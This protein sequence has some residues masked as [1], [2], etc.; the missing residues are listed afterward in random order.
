MHGIELYWLNARLRLHYEGLLFVDIR[1]ETPTKKTALGNIYN[2]R[3]KSGFQKFRL[4]H[5]LPVHPAGQWHAERPSGARAAHLVGACKILGAYPK[6]IYKA[7]RAAALFPRRGSIS[8]E[9]T[10][11]GKGSE[12]FW[13]AKQSAGRM[14]ISQWRIYGFFEDAA[15]RKQQQQLGPK[16][17]RRVLSSVCQRVSAGRAEKCVY[18]ARGSLE[19]HFALC[20]SC[21]LIPPVT[22]RRACMWQSAAAA[23]ARR[24]SR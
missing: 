17:E 16:K 21:Q 11:R 12:R 18:Y 20:Q 5:I 3:E 6:R 2:G 22:I 15:K 10:P 23:A 24:P 14:A 8:L 13:D 7:K 9:K 19:I 4:S 1:T